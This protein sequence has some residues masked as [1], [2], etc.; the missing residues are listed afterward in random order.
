MRI[1]AEKW[2][3][4]YT[5]HQDSPV[6]VDSLLMQWSRL[7]TGGRALDLACG[8]GGNAIYLARH[9][10]WVDAVDISQ[11]ALRQLS[12]WAN[13]LNLSVGCIV[14]DLDYWPIPVG[15]YDLVAVFYFFAPVR[16]A[17]LAH[18]L[19][20]GGLLFYATYN[21]NHKSEQP[22]FNEAYLVPRHGLAPY[23]KA[24]EIVWD[25]PES[26]EAKNISRLIARKPLLEQPNYRP[27][28]AE[29]SVRKS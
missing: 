10:Y 28:M 12:S 19:R 4:K 16:M 9:G 1:D 27:R 7:L 21:V 8:R 6:G 25:E 11:V 3:A 2:D 26:G 22:E 29:M 15:L 14:A 24:L 17:D 13:S 20:P 5:R 18:S 23:F